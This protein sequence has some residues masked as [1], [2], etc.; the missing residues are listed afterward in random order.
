MTKYEIKPLID[1]AT[2]QRGFDLPIQDRTPG[3]YP[4]FAANGSVGTHSH[5]KAKA[6]GVLTGRS[7]TL[8]KVHYVEEDYW[9]LNTSLWVKDF[10][11]NDPK[12]VFWLLTSMKLEQYTRGTGV[13]TLNRNLIHDVKISVPPIAEQKRIAAILDKADAVR[14][15]RREAIR[16]TEELLRSTFLE[17]FGDPVTNPKGW[18]RKKIHQVAN[19]VTGNTPPRS[20]PDNYGDY[21]EWIKSDNIADSNHFLTQASELLSE[22]GMKT[23]RLAPEGSILVTCIA[24][25]P[26]SIG[27]AA[28]VD[29]LVSFNQQI[30]AIVPKNMEDRYFLYSSLF[31]APKLVR[32]VSTQSMKGLVSKSKFENIDLIYP[33]AKERAIFCNFFENMVRT[34]SIYKESL[35]QSETFFDSLLQCAF[36]GNL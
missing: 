6:P 8:G 4:I 30:N 22:T 15:K 10:H 16:L 1:V 14:R 5:A 23:A 25:S 35:E 9:P 27:K 33:P 17:M 7:G 3:K 26:Q 19:V 34:Q 20:N 28:I 21:I 32:S 29:R 13:P 18:E 31:V 24:G 12:W 11:G 36:T 2:L